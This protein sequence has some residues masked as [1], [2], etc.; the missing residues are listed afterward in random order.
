MTT[1]ETTV[2]GQEHWTRK[3]DIK[4]Y[5]WEKRAVPGSGSNG[6][7]LWVHGSSMAST[8]TFDLTVPGRPDSSVMDWFAKRGFDNWCVDMEGY[9]RSDKSR[10]IYFDISNGADDVKAASDYIMKTRGTKQFMVYGISS[11]ALRAAM[12][13]ERNPERVSRLALDAFVWTG[14]GAPTLVERK[15]KLAD[16]IAIKKRPIDR[17]FVHSIFNRDHP[18]C[19]DTATVE[20]F[21]DAILALDHEMPTGTYVDMC[22]KLPVVDPA[23]IHAATLLMRGEFDG[24]AALDDLIEFFKRLP[25]PDKQFAMMAGISHASFQQKNYLMCYHI[26]HSFFTQPEPLYR[27]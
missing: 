6:T 26:L 16:F 24:I 23:K 13:A 15:K 12:F 7:I 27:G 4:L 14:E 9:G 17:A 19:A 10:D 21:A 1:T 20:A 18:G 2:T 5:L 25:N 8:P 22:S 3:G 11:G